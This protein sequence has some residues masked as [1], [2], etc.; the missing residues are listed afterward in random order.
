MKKVGGSHLIFK[1]NQIDYP[2]FCNW[3]T[4]VDYKFDSRPHISLHY[5]IHVNNNK[6]NQMGPIFQIT[7]DG[8]CF[9]LNKHGL[10]NYHWWFSSFYQSAIYPQLFFYIL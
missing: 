1:H 9:P 3:T 8:L 6:D 10:N 2:Q 4:L 5:I 7:I